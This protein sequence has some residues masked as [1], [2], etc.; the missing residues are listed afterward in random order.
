MLSQRTQ[1]RPTY[2]VPS[3][4]FTPMRKLGKKL[5][6]RAEGNFKPEEFGLAPAKPKTAYGEMLAYYLRMEPQ[7][8]KAAVEDQLQRLKQEKEEKEKQKL[9][10][11]D[12]SKRQ[13]SAE[14]ILSRRMDE[15][16]AAEVAET[17]EDLMYVSILEKFVLLRVEMLPRLDGLV[18]VGPINLTALTEGI[19]SK[20]A[21]ELVKEHILGVMGPVTT[22]QFSNVAVKMSTFQMAQVYAASIMFGY[23]LRRVDKRFQLERALGTLPMSKED[24]VARLEKLFSMA[25]DE[26]M[27]ISSDS[28]SEGASRSSSSSDGRSTSSSSSSSNLPVKKEKSALKRYVESF[29]QATMVETAR[30]VSTEGAALVERQTAAVL[31]DIKK[32]TQQIQS[33]VGK[34][35]TSMEQV[36]ERMAKAVEKDEIQ[37][38]TMSVGTQRRA[39]LEAVA[40]G[41]FLRDVETWVQT[42]YSLLTPLPPPQIRR[43][44]NDDDSRDGSIS[45]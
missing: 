6:V 21:L 2:R 28:D 27:N 10:L 31:G 8:F 24:A 33:A 29:D 1:L 4:V 17:L 23:F 12:S 36:M 13:D 20:E 37:T 42:E 3:L 9:Q 45:V 25:N 38:V 5:I 22:T 18:D 16:R 43:R 19:H 15:V 41:T 30:I 35:V 40:F 34:D 14:I 26:E 32:L 11:T 7:L 44:N 39:V